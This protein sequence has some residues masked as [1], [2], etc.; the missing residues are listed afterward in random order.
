[1]AKMMENG[2]ILPIQMFVGITAIQI[3]GIK[4]KLHRSQPALIQPLDDDAKD[5]TL[6]HHTNQTISL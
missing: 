4:K 1:M 3:V 2:V 5:G 6:T